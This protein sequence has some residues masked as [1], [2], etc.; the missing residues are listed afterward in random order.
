M[1][2]LSFLMDNAFRAHRNTDQ[3]E[4]SNSKRVV[5]HQI[6]GACQRLAAPVGCRSSIGAQNVG[7]VSTRVEFHHL[8]GIQPALW[9]QL[10]QYQTTIMGRLVEWRQIENY[11]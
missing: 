7:S 2:V 8:Q 11:A 9:Y 6:P 1:I 10:Q 5:L 4:D 3:K